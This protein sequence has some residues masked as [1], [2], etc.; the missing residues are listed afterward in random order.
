MEDTHLRQEEPAAKVGGGGDDD[1]GHKT[2]SGM[3]TPKEALAEAAAVGRGQWD[4]QAMTE[5]C[6]DG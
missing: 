3:I 1:A 4:S 6:L 2:S 5:R